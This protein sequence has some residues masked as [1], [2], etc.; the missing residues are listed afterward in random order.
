MKRKSGFTLIELLVVIAIIGILASILFPAF[1]SAREAARRAVCGSNLRQIGLALQMYTMDNTERMPGAGPTGRE[2]PTAL[3]AYTKSSQIFV[4]PS[5]SDAA[6]L[7]NDGGTN[8]LSF[9]YNALQIDASHYGFANPDGSAISLSGIDL[10]SE[11]I[12]IFDYLGA[13]APAEAQVTS[14]AH[15][16]DAPAD[17][18]RVASRHALGFNALFADGHVKFRKT[19]ASKVNEWTVQSD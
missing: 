10:P 9:G 14:V 17:T 8:R 12:A 19:A 3:E 5:S 13:N 15:L 6:P 16:P 2:W 4:C 11:T 18:T 7:I 1:S